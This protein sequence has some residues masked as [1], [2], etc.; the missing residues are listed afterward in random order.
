MPARAARSAG[1]CRSVHLAGRGQHWGREGCGAL[2]APTRQSRPRARQVK[3][4]WAKTG[5]CE[6]PS[7][8]PGHQSEATGKIERPDLL[9][10]LVGSESR[11]QAAGAVSGGTW[12]TRAWPGSLLLASSCPPRVNLSTALREGPKAKPTPS[13]TPLP[14]TLGTLLYGQ[15]GPTLPRPHPRPRAHAPVPHTTTAHRIF[16]GNSSP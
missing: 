16:W 6:E 4:A 14:P 10:R 13:S 8:V 9:Q 1:H 7:Q 3:G 11:E 15:V 2:G 12:E 5:A